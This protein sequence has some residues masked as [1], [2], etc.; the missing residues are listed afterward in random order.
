MAYTGYASGSEAPL[1]MTAE[2]FVEWC[3]RPSIDLGIGLDS[4]SRW[5]EE[6]YMRPASQRKGVKLYHRDAQV[7]AVR[8][9]MELQEHGFDKGFRLD[10]LPTLDQWYLVTNPIFETWV[11]HRTFLRL[12][13][14]PGKNRSYWDELDTRLREAAREMRN[15]RD[16]VLKRVIRSRRDLTLKHFEEGHLIFSHLI[17]ETDKRMSELEKYRR[18]LSLELQVWLVIEKTVF[19]RCPKGHIIRLDQAE[20]TDVRKENEWWHIWL[21]C[22]YSRAGKRCGQT[23]DIADRPWRP[24]RWVEGRKQVCLMCGQAFD[25]VKNRYRS[26]SLCRKCQRKK[27]GAKRELAQP[28][29][30]V[31]CSL[32]NVLVNTLL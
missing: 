17:D 28:L 24:L 4:L 13:P 10:I 31:W 20:V 3:S 22:S 11:L 25:L 12:E 6:G 15:A 30:G 19:A 2:E 29:K 32:C 8:K 7:H 21:A 18:D 9:I 16:E 23:F 1:L 26:M 14:G 5:E 27:E